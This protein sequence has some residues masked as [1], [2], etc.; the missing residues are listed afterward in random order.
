M[1]YCLMQL[2]LYEYT[3]ESDIAE[4]PAHICPYAVLDYY[5]KPA[6]DDSR[7]R[8]SARSRFIAVA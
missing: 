1:N 2:Y 3:E 8:S 6:C 5:Y 7:M 4:V